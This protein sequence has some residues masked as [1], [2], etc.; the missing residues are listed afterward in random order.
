MSERAL[1]NFRAKPDDI[2]RWKEH[3]HTR[4]MSLSSLIRELLN[5]DMSQS[6]IT[7]SGPVLRAT[8]VVFNPPGPEVKLEKLAETL[9]ERA[10][11]NAKCEYRLPKG[12][13]CKRCGKIHK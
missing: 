4:R 13:F 2:A 6:P 10:K 1:V 12:A 3:A 8:D 7:V 5:R 11:S 9:V